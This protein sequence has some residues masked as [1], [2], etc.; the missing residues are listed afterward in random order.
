M[1]NITNRRNESLPNYKKKEKGTV[2]IPKEQEGYVISLLNTM[3]SSRNNSNQNNSNSSE[4]AGTY[5][6]SGYT[7]S[8][9]V[10]VSDYMRT[11][12]AAHAGNG[13]NSNKNDSQNNNDNNE[14]NQIISTFITMIKSIK[15]K[16]EEKIKLNYVLIRAIF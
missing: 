11:C 4:C 5:P 7:R 8:N 13:K 6:V 12:G 16:I 10:E 9:G 1:S 3:F 14:N 15:N 2:F